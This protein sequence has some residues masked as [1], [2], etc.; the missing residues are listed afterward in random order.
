MVMKLVIMDIRYAG[1]RKMI[2]NNSEEFKKDCMVFSKAAEAF[3]KTD[4]KGT[5]AA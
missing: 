2:C 4:R 5:C 3:R 1:S